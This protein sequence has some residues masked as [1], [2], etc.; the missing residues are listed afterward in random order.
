MEKELFNLKLIAFQIKR[1]INESIIEK[2][3]I[4]AIFSIDKIYAISP[5]HD[6]YVDIQTNQGDYYTHN[7]NIALHI[8]YTSISA[9]FENQQVCHFGTKIVAYT[10]ANLKGS[11]I[12]YE[13]VDDVYTFDFLLKSQKSDNRCFI[14]SAEAKNILERCREIEG[15]EFIDE[16]EIQ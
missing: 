16:D 10:A 1:D 14:N 8:L 9:H 2:I 11:P 15:F 13:I 5:I 6:L 3:P 4:K 7:L 12:L